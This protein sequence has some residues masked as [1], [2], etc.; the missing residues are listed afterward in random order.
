MFTYLRLV[1]LLLSFFSQAFAQQELTV[2]DVSQVMQ[3]I[4]SEHVKYKEM[5]P[6]LMQRAHKLFIDQFDPDRIYLLDSEVKPYLSLTP[7]KLKSLV[8]KFNS[9]EFPSFIEMN[10]LFQEAIIRARNDRKHFKESEGVL[11]W[12]KSGSFARTHQD[13]EDRM[14]AYMYSLM[15]KETGTLDEKKQIVEAILEK[16]ENEYLEKDGYFSVHL[17]KALT[18]S[19][20][21]HSQFFEQNEAD[22]L[23]MR[24][25]KS[26]QGFGLSLEHFDH[27]FI[28][29]KIIP[30]STAE[31]SK[32]DSSWR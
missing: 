5:T 24:L 22:A 26:F 13:L 27:T 2:K 17:L 14:Q 8:K 29:V 32:K 15:N 20:D 16:K 6:E 18:A 19:L 21:A 10:S 3:G 9:G 7:Y 30:G 25:K 31:E 12:N 1:L 23:K 4:F 28:V 11:L